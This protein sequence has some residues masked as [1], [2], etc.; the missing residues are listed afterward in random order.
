MSTVREVLKCGTYLHVVI[1][2]MPRGVKRGRDAGAL[3]L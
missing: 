2:A 1:L 3:V